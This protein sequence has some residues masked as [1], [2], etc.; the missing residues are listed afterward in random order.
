MS[1]KSYIRKLASE[2]D[3]AYAFVQWAGPTSYTQVSFGPPVTGGDNLVPSQLGV[4]QVLY[5]DT[6]ASWTGNFWV[7]AIRISPKQWVIRW[8]AARTATIGGQAQTANTEAVA[9]TNLTL[10]SVSLQIY[11]GTM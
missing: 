3:T 10:E 11:T 2:G 5:V 4:Q 1:V 9:G 8:I 6:G 7:Q